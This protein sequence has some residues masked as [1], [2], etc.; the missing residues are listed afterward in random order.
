M[1][2]EVKQ[3]LERAVAQRNPVLLVQILQ[4]VPV[5]LTIF[6]RI[7]GESKYKKKCAQLTAL[8]NSLPEDMH[9]YKDAAKIITE[10]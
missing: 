3:K 6:D 8:I 9:V 7:F 4:A 1:T 5:A 10:S 2:S